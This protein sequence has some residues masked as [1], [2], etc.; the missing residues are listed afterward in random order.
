VFPATPSVSALFRLGQRDL[1]FLFVATT[2][3]ILDLEGGLVALFQGRYPRALQRRGM[4]KD[5][6][7]A[8]FS[9]MKPK[10]RMELKNLTV[11]LRRMGLSFPVRSRSTGLV[12]L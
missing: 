2:T 1:R 6:L 8:T 12:A 3:V 4:D 10:P 7:L 11:P 5:V 9:E